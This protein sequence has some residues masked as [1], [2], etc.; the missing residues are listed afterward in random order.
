L[1]V[2][3]AQIFILRAREDNTSFAAISSVLRN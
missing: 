2:I 1:R 3:V